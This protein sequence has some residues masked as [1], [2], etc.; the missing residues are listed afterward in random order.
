MS[1][2]EIIRQLLHMPCLFRLFTGLYCLGCGGTRAVKSLL[3]GRLLESFRYHPLVPYMAAAAVFLAAAYFW[4]GKTKRPER[5]HGCVE[6][7][8]Y[9]GIG[10]VLVNWIVKN[11]CLAVFGLDLLAESL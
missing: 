3:A 8:L 2:T 7:V 6:A 10:I 4:T 11:V 1:I 9:I 5:Y